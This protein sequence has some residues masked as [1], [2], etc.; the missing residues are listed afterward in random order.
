MP[1]PQPP[2]PPPHTTSTSGKRFGR[3]SALGNRFRRSSFLSK[4]GIFK[5]ML[6]DNDPYYYTHPPYNGYTSSYPSSMWYKRYQ[7]SYWG[8]ARNGIFDSIFNH[9]TRAPKIGPPIYST[10]LNAPAA[11]VTSAVLGLSTN[12]IFDHAFNSKWR[13]YEF[14]NSWPSAMGIGYPP[15]SGHLPYGS[16][17][18]FASNV[19]LVS[20]GSPAMML[21]LYRYGSYQYP[22]YFQ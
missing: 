14:Q 1:T 21:P 15:F 17:P 3:L 9:S 6:H 10:G 13:D 18:Y 5:R 12:G 22:Y 2:P 16:F 11:Q 20:P 8:L 7:D 19:D 4:D